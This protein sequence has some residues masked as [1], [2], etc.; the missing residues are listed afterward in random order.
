MNVTK[1]KTMNSKEKHSTAQSSFPKSRGKHSQQGRSR[2]F[3]HV[4]TLFQNGLQ[5]YSCPLR[6]ISN[7]K[8]EL[9]A[10]PQ[11]VAWVWWLQ[12][13]RPLA[14]LLQ[15]QV[16]VQYPDPPSFQ[17]CRVKSTW[18]SGMEARGSRS[19]K[20]NY[21]E[22]HRPVLFMVQRWTSSETVEESSTIHHNM[23]DQ[24]KLSTVTT[25]AL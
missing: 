6:I 4:L 14:S 9:L 20:I 16:N 15:S 23:I 12:A 17:P 19:S 10:S 1:T 8:Q 11:R 2:H 18:V 3:P 22:P 13:Q 5:A 25:F 21:K 24:L 7:I